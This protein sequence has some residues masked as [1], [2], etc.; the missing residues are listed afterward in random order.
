MVEEARPLVVRSDQG[1]DK[2]PLARVEEAV[3]PGHRELHGQA[4]DTGH[5]WGNVFEHS[6]I[7]RG[8]S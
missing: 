7:D 4:H 3:P 2:E 5:S 1:G 6:R 8:R